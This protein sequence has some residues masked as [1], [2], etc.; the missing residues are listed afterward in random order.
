MT[1]A[2][3]RLRQKAWQRVW[4][5]ALC[6]LWLSVWV[7]LAVAQ[8]GAKL[9]Q[10]LAATVNTPDVAASTALYRKALGYR[11][12]EQSRVSAALARSWGAPAMAGRPQALLQAASGEAVYLRLVEGTP[13]SEYR[14]LHSAGWNAIELLVRDP[15]T[16]AEQLRDTAL[17]QLGEPAYLAPGSTI[18]AT[19][20]VGPSGEVFYFTADTAQGEGSTLARARSTVDRPFILVLGGEDATALAAF[21]QRN[22]N[23][24]VGLNTTM[25]VPLIARAQQREPDHAFALI[26]LR[27]A[28]FSHS[29]EIDGYGPRPP[30][31]RIQDELPPGVSLASFVV[32]DLDQFSALPL[33][34]S[35]AVQAGAPYNGRRSATLVGPAGELIEL[36]ELKRQV[37]P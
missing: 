11:L 16:L 19:Q 13:V 15:D 33:L 12:V 1:K 10:I 6:L 36:V 23:L 4:Q 9:L 29:L 34:Q 7:P 8:D 32:E 17:T 3:R 28:A 5:G 26:L 21:Y 35:P 30:R 37:N 20:Y 22:F 2:D 31:P 24:P 14:P 25:A 27:L 18:R